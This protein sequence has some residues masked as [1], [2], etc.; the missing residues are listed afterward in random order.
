MESMNA[1]DLHSQL[2]SHPN[3]QL[4]A[5]P[6]SSST[7][8][9]ARIN[10]AAIALVLALPMVM[11]SPLVRSLYSLRYTMHSDVLPGGQD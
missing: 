3:S 7:T 2:P 4:I 6:S 9:F 8:M 10:A 11:A 1:L 5:N